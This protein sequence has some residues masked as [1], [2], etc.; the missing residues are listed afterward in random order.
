M[1][2]SDDKAE[3]ATVKTETQEDELNETENRSL[4]DLYIDF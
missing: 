3:G 1:E 4:L 2:D